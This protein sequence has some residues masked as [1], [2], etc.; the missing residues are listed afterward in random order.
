VDLTRPLITLACAI[1]V[2][3]S[4]DTAQAAPS[5]NSLPAP[6]AKSHHLG[7][8]QGARDGDKDGLSNWG[9][10]RAGTNPRRRDSDRDGVSD[11]L[12]DRDKDG[13]INADEVTAATDPRKRDS[14]GD[15]IADG[16]EDRDRDGLRNADERPTGHDLSKRDGDGDGVA[17]GADNPGKVTAV[18]TTSVSIRLYTTGKTLT[19]TLSADSWIDCTSTALG[20]VVATGAG[21]GAT[22]NAPA[23]SGGIGDSDSSE[24]GGDIPDA[25]P[26][27][28]VDPP[29]DADPEPVEEDPARSAF[30]S[31]RATASQVGD[32]DDAD[33]W[34]AD[35][36]DS[37]SPPDLGTCATA[38]R[39]GAIVHKAGLEGS[40]LSELELMKPSI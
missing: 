22:P 16:R 24:G 37:I 6:W 3:V 5:R 26:V 1:A 21:A 34:D 9:E 10:Y 2:F 18:S 40:M 32:D 4:V 8:K 7:A 28:G 19:A 35:G 29:P 33:A 27:P 12:E 38:L 14:D 25:D 30:M 13:L 23:P 20:P 31:A 36:T 11:A 15:R 17:D 39:V